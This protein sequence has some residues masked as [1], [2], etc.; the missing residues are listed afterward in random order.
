MT[1]YAPINNLTTTLSQELYATQQFSA[2]LSYELM[3]GEFLNLFIQKLVL[4][5]QGARLPLG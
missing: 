2:R 4:V 1:G 5:P 3:D